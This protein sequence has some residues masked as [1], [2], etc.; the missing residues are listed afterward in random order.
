MTNSPIVFDIFNQLNVADN[1]CRILGYEK[2]SMI[3]HEFPDEEILIK[4]E[5][6][7]KNKPIMLV[8][9][10]DRPNHKIAALVFTANT[11]RELGSG[12]ITLICPYLAYMR[13]DKQFNACE[14]VT[15]IYFA[16]LLSAN[17]DKLITI[18]PHL[19]RWHSLDD[20]FSISSIVLHAT[21]PI[22]DWIK[23]H[24]TKPL[25]IGP[26]A[27]SQQWVAETAKL[28]D[29]P[30]LVVEKIRTGDHDVSST[31][32]QLEIYT[33]YHLVLL[34]DIISTGATM[35]ETIRHIQSFG[36]HNI[37]CIGVHAIFAG[38]T[39]EALMATGINE[40]VTCNTIRHFSNQIDVSSLIADSLGK[41]NK[42]WS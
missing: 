29:A 14:G 9:A 18:D 32:P 41:D 6:N 26:D 39:Y 13:Q 12:P 1:I 10:L 4:I 8:A 42:C 37:T 40:I 20:I 19:H 11:L 21:R 5:S 23:S 24:I 33:D 30:Y 36:I 15:S 16:R 28:C 38:D 2:G 17:V 35:L 3:I 27:E 22:S 7:V 25:L 34:D 31:I